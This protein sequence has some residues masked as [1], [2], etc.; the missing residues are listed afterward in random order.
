MVET[1]FIASGLG[2]LPCHTK[3][4]PMRIAPMIVVCCVADR[5]DKSRICQ[6]RVHVWI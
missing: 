3:D 1:R 2:A 6:S 4:H 5:R